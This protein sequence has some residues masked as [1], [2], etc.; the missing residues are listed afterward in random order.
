V[1]GVVL[2]TNVLVSALL[3]P[4]GTAAKVLDLVCSGTLLPYYDNRILNEYQ[5]VLFRPKFSFDP[6]SA[7]HLIALLKD[8]GVPTVAKPFHKPFPDETD[9]KFYEVAKTAGCY[10]ATGNAKHFPKEPFVVSPAELRKIFPH[11]IRG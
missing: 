11:N 5:S 3:T 6:E 9:R 10:L 2:D 4:N 1:R 8:L 7:D